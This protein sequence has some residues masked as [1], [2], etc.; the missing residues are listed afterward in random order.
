MDDHPS[1]TGCEALLS[2]T[3][4][5]RELARHL[6]A[7]SHAAD[8]LAQDALAAAL[9]HP[10]PDDRPIRSW[11]AGIVRNLARER[12]RGAGNRSARELAA[13]HG[14]QVPSSADLLDRLESHRAVVEAVARLEEPYRTAILLRYFEGLSPSAI[15]AR[16]ASPLRTVHTRLHRA[17]ARLREDL[18][19]AHGGDGRSWLLALIPFARGSQEWSTWGVGALMMDVKLKIAVAVVALVGVC[20]TIALWPGEEPRIE[21]GAVAIVANPAVIAPADPPESRALEDAPRVVERSA[22]EGP[23]PPVSVESL[24]A[25]PAKLSGRVIDVDRAP[26]AGV[27]V[28]YFDP[29]HGPQ[30]GLEA[31]TKPDGSFD[32]EPPPGPGYIDVVSPGWASVLRPELTSSHALPTGRE[33][34]LV[35]ARSVTLGGTVVDEER[36]PIPDAEIGL[37]VPFGLRSRFDTILDGSSTVERRVKTGPDGRFELEGVATFPGAVLSTKHVAYL[38]DV[39]ELPP[40]DDLAV[41]I[42]LRPA[43]QGP[44]RLVGV[45]VD[46]EGSPVEEAW[47][48]MGSGSTKSGPSGKFALELESGG[49]D[50]TLFG[51]SGTQPL[52]AVKHGHLPAEV[53]RPAGNADWPDPLILRL[54]GP[55]PGIAGRVVDAE[56]IPVPKAQVWIDEE[57]HFGLIEIENGEM[58]MSA[59]ASIEG[60]LRGDPWT[61]RVTADSDGRFELSGLLPRD[62]RVRAL[63]AKRLLATTVS[64]SAGARNVEIRMPKEDLYEIVSG[65]VTSLSGEPAAG[66]HVALERREAGAQG[67]EFDRLQN[68]AAR[69]DAEGRFAFEKVS[70]AVNAVN[71]SGPELDMMGFRYDIRPGDDVEGLSIAVPLRVHV[72]IDPGGSTGFDRAAILDEKEEMLYLSVDHGKSSYAMREIGLEEG[73]SEPFSVSEAARTLVLYKGKDEVRRMALKLLRGELNTIRP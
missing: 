51:G 25:V 43:K 2:Q 62:Y 39:R 55:P 27:R 72:Q 44:E 5:V 69:T 46:L 16:T 35:V 42:V 21:P 70:R 50:P 48:G 45:V 8:D 38:A 63:D 19:R 59:G 29:E 54:G 47:V 53:A 13:A 58:M 31:E 56:G 3:G 65:R 49:Q 15:A 26:V 41:E 34:V 4:W 68:A 12:R 37:P 30:D 24:A 22:Q 7:D 23:R 64:L 10:P 1:S 40:H 57:T 73:R 61:R 67:P 32:L 52:R 36:R 17:F 60:M 66:V 33:F 9:V 11:L 28:R 20:S 14:G 6:T 71:V 18:D